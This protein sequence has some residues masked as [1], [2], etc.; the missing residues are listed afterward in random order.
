MP[1]VMKVEGFK[2][3]EQALVELVNTAGV[4]TATGKNLA[5]R[6]L[7]RAAEPVESAAAGAAPVASGQLRTSITVGTQLS[8]RQRK[9]SPK[10]SAVEVYVGAGPLPQAHMQEFGT[11][12][13]APQPF[14]RPAWDSNKG[15]ALET[16]KS[17]LW[18]EI[19]R[20]AAR[21]ARKAA[22]LAAKSS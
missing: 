4:S 18:S 21:A 6:V 8:P 20:V 19:K 3:L 9:S 2:E 12:H 7:T 14:M 15:Q 13:N 17:G 1:V 5:R 22:R 16:I 10:A 11:A